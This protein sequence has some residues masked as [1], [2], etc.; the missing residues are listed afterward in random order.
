MAKFVKGQS[1]N[2][3]GRPKVVAA[4]RAL[5]QS[6]NAE[7]IEGLARIARSK[8]APHAARVAAW[9]ELLDRGNGKAPS[10]LEDLDAMKDAARLRLQAL[11]DGRLEVLLD[12]IDSPPGTTQH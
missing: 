2:P 1:G 8:K 11:S 9:K 6:Y 7:A 12:A 5:A 4:V 3:S 10:A